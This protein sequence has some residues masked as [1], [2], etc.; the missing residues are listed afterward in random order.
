MSD[1]IEHRLTRIEDRQALEQLRGAYCH[2]VDSRRWEALADLFTQ[3]G[4]FIGF[5]HAI[6]RPQILSFFRDT[7]SG[8]N[9]AMWHFCTNPTLTIEGET[10][11]GQLSLQYLSRKG[12]VSYVSA[13][14]YD[15]SFRK[16]GGRWRFRRRKLTF[17]YYAPL[18]EGFVGAPTYIRPDGTPLTGPEIEARLSA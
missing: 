2:L 11:T 4:E 14:H 8:L 6:G 5:A 3:D 17:Y 12:G 18:S 13:G 10:A 9:E 7:V 15:D 16:E 1:S